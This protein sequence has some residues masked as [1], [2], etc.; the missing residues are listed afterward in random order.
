[1]AGGHDHSSLHL[2]QESPT[3]LVSHFFQGIGLERL[4]ALSCLCLRPGATERALSMVQFA[5]VSHS[6]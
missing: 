6:G 1:M 5:A 2:G 3:A 4:K